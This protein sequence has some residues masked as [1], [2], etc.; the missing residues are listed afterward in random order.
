MIARLA[1]AGLV[2]ALAAPALAQG[3]GAQTS[4]SQPQ[5]PTT[6]NDIKQIEV[7]RGPASAVWGA[8]A[9][10]GV[11]N[12]ITR[13]PR[14]M[15]AKGASNEFTIGAGAFNRNVTGVDA[16]GNAVS[17]AQGSGS[18]FYVN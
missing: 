13:T 18:M 17:L 15:A 2:M 12:V 16:K 9:M 3:T 6:P 5:Q 14:E 7:I 10:A 1:A 11:V 8:N 4:S